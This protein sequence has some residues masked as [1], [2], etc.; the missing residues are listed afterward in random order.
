MF[1]LVNNIF[2]PILK[3]QKMWVALK[4]KLILG[5]SLSRM[6]DKLPKNRNKCTRNGLILRVV[7][8]VIHYSGDNCIELFH[9]NCRRDDD[10][11][12]VSFLF[13]PLFKQIMKEQFSVVMGILRYLE[14]ISYIGGPCYTPSIQRREWQ[15]LSRY[16]YTCL[17]YQ[18]RNHKHYGQQWWQTVAIIHIC[19]HVL[20]IFSCAWT[21]ISW[22]CSL[23]HKTYTHSHIYILIYIQ[24][25]FTK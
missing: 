10:I 19:V 11:L 12:H 5:A 9:I 8:R 20:H 1:D 25:Y 4:P 21:M 2:N 15:I 17:W 18:N 23:K 3:V 6:I 24:C 14:V 22:P 16:D 7:E 13:S